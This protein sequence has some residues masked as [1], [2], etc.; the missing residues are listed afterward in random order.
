MKKVLKLCAYTFVVLL[1]V[2]VVVTHFALPPYLD[3]NY[4][5][6]TGVQTNQVFSDE[7]QQFH[8][9]LTIIDLHCDALIWGRDLTE[10]NNRG[11]VDIPRLL[12]GNVAIQVFSVPTDVPKSRSRWGVSPDGLNLITLSAITQ[13]WPLSTWVSL[14]SRAEYLGGVLHQV[15]KDSDDKF[16]VITTK[17]SLNTYLEARKVNRNVSAGIL[18]IEG[19]HALEGKLENLDRLF[20][21]GY[22]IMGLTHFY[23]NKVGGASYGIA[24]GGLTE[25]GEDVI[26]RME[27]L[28]IIVDLAHASE[29]LIDET[30]EIATKPVIVSHTGVRGVCDRSRNLS[31]E[32]VIRIAKT[33]GV[34][35]IGFWSGAVCGG[36][37]S[38]IVRS[39]RYV[40]DLVGVENVALGSDFDGDKLPFDV[41]SIS[42]ITNSLIEAG[43]SREE[44][45]LIMGGNALR[46]LQEVLPH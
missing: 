20:D 30:L 43:F 36:T 22:R 42:I 27:E 12:E 46:I 45:G 17:S 5:R 18:A 34:I 23:D 10:R 32:H 38:E 28:G 40:A 13:F 33:G 25:F 44:V 6:I 9:Q 7:I 3:R 39:I 35:G 11:H 29:E 24:R 37:V 19:L 26:Q 2:A 14:C 31:D 21:S 4:N 8:S 1:L 16:Q 41:A 15:S